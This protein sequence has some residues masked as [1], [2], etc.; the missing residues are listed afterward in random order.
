MYIPEP[1]RAL[2]PGVRDCFHK[3]PLLGINTCV[4]PLLLLIMKSSELTLLVTAGGE[5]ARW[6]KTAA[7]TQL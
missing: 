4:I 5:A 3:A 1:P 2:A 7:N 6:G